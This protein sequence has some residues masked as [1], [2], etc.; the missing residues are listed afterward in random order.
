MGVVEAHDRRG[1][2]VDV[3]TLLIRGPVTKH[4]VSAEQSFSGCERLDPR[5]PAIVGCGGVRPARAHGEDAEVGDFMAGLGDRAHE[6]LGI[7]PVP[8]PPV[9]HEEGIGGR[10]R[11]H[12]DRAWAC[13]YRRASRNAEG[14]HVDQAAH[15]S[16]VA[17]RSRRD[18]TE[19]SEH[20]EPVVSLTLAGAQE[21]VSAAYLL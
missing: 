12:A 11:Y 7:Q 4:H 21:E 2:E 17:V 9:P 18:P 6:Q 3:V 15:V 20:S 10:P 19:G 8:E 16:V 5:S 1:V 14:D 13:P